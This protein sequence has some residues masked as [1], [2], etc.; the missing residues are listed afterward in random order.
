MQHITRKTLVI[1]T[2]HISSHLL[3]PPLCMSLS[4]NK[5]LT[6]AQIFAG[7][8]NL[9]ELFSFLQTVQ[10]LV[11]LQFKK[12]WQ[13]YRMRLASYKVEMYMPIL[14]QDWQAAQCL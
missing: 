12:K 8:R 2:N 3:N 7:K 9:T 13:Q 14:L 10:L 1:I 5:P 4:L 6:R 11:T